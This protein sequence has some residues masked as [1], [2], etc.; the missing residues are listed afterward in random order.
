MA[1]ILDTGFNGLRELLVF[2]TNRSKSKDVL[3]NNIL[4]ELR[5]NLS[6]LEHRNAAGVD[7]KA[8]VHALQS[9]AIEKAFTA[10]Y[11]FNQL[12]SKRKLSNTMLLNPANPKYLHWDMQRFIYSIEGKI[13]DLKHIYVIYPD[14]T[15]A[16]V[17]ITQRLNNLFYQLLQL[18]AFVYGTRK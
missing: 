12:T 1:D 5:D 13:N 9:D 15:L 7:Q 10:N 11:N 6:L 4:R 14:I 16:P 8:L 3:A 18:S 17:N 2:L